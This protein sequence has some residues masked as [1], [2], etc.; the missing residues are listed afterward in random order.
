MGDAM[1]DNARAYKLMQSSPKGAVASHTELHGLVGFL[2]SAAD[3][4]AGSAQAGMPLNRGTRQRP[5]AVNPGARRAACQRGTADAR[6]SM[7]DDK[8][9]SGG[10]RC[11]MGALGYS[12]ARCDSLLSPLGNYC[13]VTGSGKAGA[14][15]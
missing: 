8:Q 6:L 3:W 11:L 12:R 13:L 5:A 4:R 15:S 14:A 10:N 7:G 2:H 9:A 1:A